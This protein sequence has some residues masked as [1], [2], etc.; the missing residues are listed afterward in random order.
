MVGPAGSS[1]AF[2]LASLGISVLLLDKCVFPRDKPC[3]DAV[4]TPAID[5]LQEMG[6]FKT[7]MDNNEGHMADNGGVVSPSG[8]SYIGRS[9]GKL[10]RAAAVAVKRIN[11]DYR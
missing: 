6:T 2:Y 1:C 11:L 7:I 5:I 8:I 4:C 10:G 3:G 9:L